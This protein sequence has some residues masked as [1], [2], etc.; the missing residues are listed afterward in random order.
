[1]R[2]G[3]CLRQE[4]GAGLPLRRLLQRLVDDRD[5]VAYAPW[6]GEIRVEVFFEN[7]R[8]RI[9]A[10]EGH[11][12][13]SSVR[14]I[15]VDA[16]VDTGAVM[17]LIPQEIVERLGLAIDGRIIVALAND[18][19]VELDRARNLSLRIGERQMDT[20]CLVGPPTCEVLIGQLVLE[21]LD[22]VPDPL[23]RA[24]TPRPESPYL[25]ALKLK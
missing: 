15:E 24:V 21:R 22:L 18:E 11:L 9:L 4:T 7:G 20:D 16:L 12:N 17:T 10:Q 25:P 6:M 5:G 2:V 8:D 3:T 14:G 1:M 19:K 13:P 23:R